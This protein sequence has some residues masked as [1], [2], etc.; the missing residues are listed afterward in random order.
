MGSPSQCPVKGMRVC[1]YE[2][3][4]DCTGQLVIGSRGIAS[5]YLCDDAVDDAYQNI[6]GEN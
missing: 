1:R 2:T 5:G 6:R 4:E 3:W